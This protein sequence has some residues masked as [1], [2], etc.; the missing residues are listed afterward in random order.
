MKV[1]TRKNTPPLTFVPRLIQIK[2][3]TQKELNTLKTMFNMHH[4]TLIEQLP[5]ALDLEDLLHHEAAVQFI[6]KL[7]SAVSNA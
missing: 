3:D 4:C 7:Y 6:Y 1:T 2:V 5:H